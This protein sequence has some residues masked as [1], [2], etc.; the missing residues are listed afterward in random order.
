MPLP[1]KTASMSFTKGMGGVG[2]L[3]VLRLYASWCV[4][5]RPATLQVG[6][7]ACFPLGQQQLEWVSDSWQ[8]V[9]GEGRG[10]LQVLH[11]VYAFGRQHLEPVSVLYGG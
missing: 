9:W 2:G 11:R 10:G 4:C 8:S 5:L 7:A 1:S 6:A 3:Q